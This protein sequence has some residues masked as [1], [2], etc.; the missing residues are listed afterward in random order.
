MMIIRPSRPEDAEPIWDI[1]RPTLRA[2]ETYAV[3]PDLTR[4]EA[5]A[6]WFSPA[7]EVFVAEEDG[8]VLGTYYMHANQPGG[9]RHVANCG[10]MTATAAQGRG[11]AR[12]MGEHSLEHAKRRGFNAMQFNFVVST[13]ERAV[14]LWQRLGFSIAGTLPGAFE[15]P[16]LG[17]VDVYV[18]FRAL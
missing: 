6:Y 18:M 4:E 3:S 2:A 13:N 16:R 12:A 11:V 15:H 1:L 5:L 14:G 10:Y 9:G 17:F 8:R 7:H